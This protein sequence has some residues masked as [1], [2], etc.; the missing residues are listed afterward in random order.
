MLSKPG[1]YPYRVGVSKVFLMEDKIRYSEVACRLIIATKTITLKVIGEHVLYARYMFLV[2][3]QVRSRMP[4]KSV[5]STNWQLVRWLDGI[6]GI[7]NF[8]LKQTEK[9]V[10]TITIFL[11]FTEKCKLKNTFVRSRFYS[12]CKP[13]LNLKLVTIVIVNFI[14]KK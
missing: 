1:M 7:L 10:C 6:R 13:R 5:F 8:C 14:E 11:D 12:Q 3:F 9:Y 4:V 2:T